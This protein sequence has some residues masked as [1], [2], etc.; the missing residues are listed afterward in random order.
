MT[1][2]DAVF[3]LSVGT[4]L[5]GVFGMSAKYALKSKCEKFSCCCGCL[6]IDR[7][8]DLEVKEEMKAMEL[9]VKTD[10]EDEVANEEKV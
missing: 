8:V 5:V 10:D 6:T 3:F 1:I 9:G 7:R 4:L 2:F